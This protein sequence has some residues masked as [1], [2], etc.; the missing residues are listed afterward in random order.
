MA[1]DPVSIIA[2]GE[3]SGTSSMI[4]DGV[5]GVWMRESAL[6]QKVQ[7]VGD[8]PRT[9]TGGSMQGSVAH[10]LPHASC[11]QF[12]RAAAA[13]VIASYGT[14][15]SSQPAVARGALGALLCMTHNYYNGPPIRPK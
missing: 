9:P 8:I 11:T 6:G 10:T 5:R 13:A 14:T 12:A 15:V 2:C 1:L 7:V 4:A 3:R